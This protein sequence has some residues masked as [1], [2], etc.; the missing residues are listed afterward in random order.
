EVQFETDQKSSL[1]GELLIEIEWIQMIVLAGKVQKS[2]CEF[3]PATC[4]T[5]AAV[6]VELPEIVTRQTR[7]VMIIGLPAPV[8]SCLGEKSAG[9]IKERVEIESMQQCTIVGIGEK[10]FR[11]SRI[12]CFQIGIAQSVVGSKGPIASNQLVQADNERA[13]LVV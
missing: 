6:Q 3:C 1:P 13:F 12:A 5:V 4:E 7:F 8:G 9:V 10:G 11:H 2:Q